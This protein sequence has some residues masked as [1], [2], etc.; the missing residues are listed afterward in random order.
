MPRSFYP[1]LLSLVVGFFPATAQDSDTEKEAA[2]REAAASVD[3]DLR[4]ALEELA[5]LREQIAAEKPEIAREANQIAA[6]LRENRRS[7]DLART[8]RDAAEDEFKKAE[9]DL[10]V[11]RDER[12]YIESLLFDFRKNYESQ[13]SLARNEAQREILDIHTTEGRLALIDQ[14]LDRAETTGT[15]ERV[16]GEALSEDGVVVGGTFVEAGPISWFL[17][18]DGSVSGLVGS[19]SDLRPE[20]V[21]GTADQK[22]IRDLIEGKSSNP[23]FD[24]TLGTAVAL[25]ETETSLLSH[26]EKGGFW[27][28]PILLLALVALIAAMAKWVQLARIR[29]LRPGV[30]QSVLDAVRR[31]DSEQAEQIAA[32]I[33]HPAR[34]LLTRGI[35]MTAPGE[36]KSREQ[37]EEALYERY[38]EALPP[39]QRGLALIAITSA[40][41]PLLGLLGTVTGM[42]ET[43]RLINIFG[44]GDAKSLASGI[45][46]A[47]VTT[48]FGLIVAIPAL[49]AHAL[50]SRKIQGIRNTMEMT[51][52]A[53][54]N[55][56][57]SSEPP[58]IEPEKKQEPVPT[59]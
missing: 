43:F 40:T 47:L 12:N 9:T 4:I 18:G 42:I 26:V 1:L 50:L 38:V 46:E 24:P 2:Y 8:A 57:P 49:I 34:R 6:D 13:Q 17:S 59:N 28:W 15:I 5:A 23:A 36:R 7:A 32:T 54:I 16:E 56:L 10:K 19:D 35:E 25:T 3:E 45:S 51:S 41:A 53:F 44:T 37:I 39:L 52:L 20:L 11:W 30:V 27:I 31:G 58:A 21:V 33:R 14:V 55:G 48:E 29:E 22:A